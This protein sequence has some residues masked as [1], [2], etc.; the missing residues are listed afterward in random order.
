MGLPVF[1]TLGT[2]NAAPIHTQRRAGGV[3]IRL[4]AQPGPCQS[5]QRGQP[6]N[7]QRGASASPPAFPPMSPTALFI[8][9]Y[10]SFLP[11]SVPGMARANYRREL[12]AALF[13]PVAVAAVEGTVVGVLVKQGYEG[14]APPTMLAF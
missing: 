13:F 2:A 5:V 10:G 11:S 3:S 6:S 4:S 14:V 1:R 12:T 9:A 8:K 7:R